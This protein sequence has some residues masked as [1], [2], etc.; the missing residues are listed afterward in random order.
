[1]KL[2]VNGCSYSWGGGM[3][4]IHYHSESN[5][6]EIN[7]L[8][9]HKK[10]PS[11]TERLQK[12]Y[13]HHLGKLLKADEVINLS[14]GGGSNERI[15]RTTLDFYTNKLLKNE[16]VTNY[17]NVIQWTSVDRIEMYD[18]VLDGTVY[19]LPNAV[20]F[21]PKSL[22]YTFTAEGHKRIIELLS[23]RRDEYYKKFMSKKTIVDKTF[24]QITTLGT[25]FE[26][27]NIPYLFCSMNPSTTME[28][29]KDEPEKMKYLNKFNWLD[30]IIDKSAITVYTGAPG[31]TQ[32]LCK[33]GHPNEYGHIEISNG[34]YKWIINNKLTGELV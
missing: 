15:V 2:Y 16:D 11:N 13:S 27:H 3:Y 25:F 20:V 18:D 12:V 1:M 23:D 32:Y 31:N 7:F 33:S 34:L 19:M 28:Y 26:R 10:H 22:S 4:D 29:F 30:S 24:L 8:S 17:F 14:M 21:E 9:I 5:P 6:D